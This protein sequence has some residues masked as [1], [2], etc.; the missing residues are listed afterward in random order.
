MLRVANS[1]QPGPGANH[2]ALRASN[3]RL[4][5][6]LIRAHGQLSKAQIAELTGLTAQ[7][8]SVIS[9]S[10]VEAGLLVEG[11]AVRGKV[12]QPSV[13]L[14]LNPD[15]AMFL[16]VHIG[17]GELRAALVNFTGGVVA[18]RASTISSPSTDRVARFI[19]D[20]ANRMRIGEDP[21]QRARFQ[22]IGVSIASSSLTQ[23]QANIPWQDLETS[24][25]TLGQTF[26]V[27]TYVSS[28]ALA[29]CSAELIYGLGTGVADFLYVFIDNSISGGL[30]Q[31]GRIRFSRDET[32]A[33]VGKVLVPSVDGRTV[34]LRS[35]A[36]PL[37]RK[38]TAKSV[39]L[40]AH[41]I[42]IALTAANSLL[43]CRTVILDGA[44]SRDLLQQITVRLR[45]ALAQL[46][47]PEAS[48]LSV[49][50]GSR[51][52]KNVALGAACLPLADRFYPS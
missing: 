3:E 12:G 38:P 7:T 51:E 29:A 18:E 19:R 4:V 48:E 44:I 11:A 20:A 14:S 46:D 52:R 40:V 25:D 27:A 9:R 49:R 8:A 10:L 17:H 24:L 50:E 41:G 2:V 39:D 23:I 31:E 16:G 36:H 43:P 30:V 28:D 15:G 6:S 35:L 33:N 26:G 21:R 22:G 37:L 5:L 13:P 32:G 1:R 42:A 34:P 45:A 47:V